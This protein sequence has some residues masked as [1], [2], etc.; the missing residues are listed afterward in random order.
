[1]IKLL[2]Y[3][4]VLMLQVPL[5]ATLFSHDRAVWLMQKGQYGSA[6]DLLAKQLSHANENPELLYD[7]GVATYKASNNI[8]SADEQ[9]DAQNTNA[10]TT[11]LLASKAYFEKVTQLDNASGNLKEKSY[12]NAGNVAVDLNKL[13]EAID[14]YEKALKI[15]PENKQTKHNLEKVKEMLNKQQQEQ[16]NQQDKQEQNKDNKDQNQQKNN[17][18]KQQKNNQDKQENDQDK[19]ENDQ[20]KDQQQKDGDNKQDQDK[21]DS[22]QKDQ[23]N[24][25]EKQ[26]EKQKDQQNQSN[27]QK[28]SQ[29]EQ[30][31]DKEEQDQKKQ[32][33]D[34]NDRDKKE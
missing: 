12:F 6:K 28:Q 29:D 15:N 10:Q 24:K 16:K 11:E 1:M 20:D 21:K 23:K 18:D 7:L 5:Q 13:Q 32:Q 14:H 17:K 9:S 34:K 31:Q 25:N 22:E 33:Q 8:I 3:I 19:Q 30:Q 26:Q 27:D 2:F 4:I